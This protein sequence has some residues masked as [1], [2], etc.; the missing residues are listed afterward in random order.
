MRPSFSAGAVIS[1]RGKTFA[2]PA[3]ARKEFVAYFQEGQPAGRS[4][5]LC[6]HEPGA[7]SH[8]VFDLHDFELGKARPSLSLYRCRWSRARYRSR[9]TT[10]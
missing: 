9:P 4:H 3:R 5:Y 10:V 6:G 7:Y 2:Q 1:K 8:D